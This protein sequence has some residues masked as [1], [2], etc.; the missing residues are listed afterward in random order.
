MGY[1]DDLSDVTRAFC[2]LAT[3]PH[4]VDEWME[5]LEQYVVLLYDPTSSQTSVNQAHKKLFTL[6]GRVIG[7]LPPTQAALIE[8]TKRAAYLAGHCWEQVMVSGPK[9]PPWVINGE[10]ERKWVD[11]K[12]TG[13]TTR[14]SQGLL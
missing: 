13:S 2:A 5:L 12:L 3:T 14:S 10:R 4:T 1:M 6:K 7:G 11:G 8:H 9:L